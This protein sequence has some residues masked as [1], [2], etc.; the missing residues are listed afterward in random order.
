MG[1]FSKMVIFIFC[2]IGLFSLLFSLIPAQFFEA[3]YS[4][5]IGVD[6]EVAEYFSTANVT[7]YGNAGSDNMSYQYSSYDDHPGAPEFGSGLPENQYV[8]VWWGDTMGNPQL[9]FRHIEAVWWGRQ[10]HDYL[11]F[12]LPNKT[13]VWYL[14]PDWIELNYDDAINGSVYYTWCNHISVSTIITFNQSEYSTIKEAMLDGEL[15]YV[16]SYEPNWNA[17]SV[18]AF[19][20]LGQLLTF[21]NPD[22]GIPGDAGIVFNTMVA[23]PFWIMTA[24]LILLVI[25]SLIPFIKG[26]DA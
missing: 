7:L 19:T 18:S 26:I 4:A 8:E 21:Q 24:I 13:R 1:S 11:R 20:I 2:T 9:E 17:S 22:L 14:H 23:L 3:S 15:G 16:L 10:L 25:Q 5:S 6:K 12:E